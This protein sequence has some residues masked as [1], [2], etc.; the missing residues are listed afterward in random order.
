MKSEVFGPLSAMY[1]PVG[2][3]W[4]WW[5]SSGAWVKS[6]GSQKWLELGRKMFGLRLSRWSLWP[7]TSRPWREWPARRRFSALV[8][9]HVPEARESR[10][11]Q[12]C[13][14]GDLTQVIYRFIYNFINIL[15]IFL[16]KNIKF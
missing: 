2:E 4:L 16:I 13:G 7:A 6:N 10:V 15:K 8:E 12:A 1:G 11:G 3:P 14:A 5:W 9:S